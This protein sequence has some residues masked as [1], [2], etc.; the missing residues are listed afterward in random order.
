MAETGA[1]LRGGAIFIAVPE[2]A[3]MVR[4]EF[5]GVEPMVK[6]AGENEQ[7]H[8]V[9][10]P[11]QESATGLLNSPD[12]SYTLQGRLAMSELCNC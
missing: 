8:P 4:A 5:T 1:G 7:F 10:K 2:L 9:G 11:V 3:A 6:L 12:E